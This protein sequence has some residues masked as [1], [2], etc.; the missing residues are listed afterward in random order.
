MIVVVAPQIAEKILNILRKNP[1]GKKSEIIGE[2]TD[3][4]KGRV[5]L[6]TRYGGTRVV[7]MLLGE[8]FPRIC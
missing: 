5:G 2:I 3:K 8:Q 1:L 6:K 7:D 4:F